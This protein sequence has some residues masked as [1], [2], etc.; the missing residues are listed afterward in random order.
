MTKVIATYKGIKFCK[1]AGTSR[2]ECIELPSAAVF[3]A[4]L[5]SS[6][7]VNSISAVVHSGSGVVWCDVQWCIYSSS[8]VFWCRL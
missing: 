7:V 8:A 2:Q 4:A 1:K 3:Q 6:A 5:P